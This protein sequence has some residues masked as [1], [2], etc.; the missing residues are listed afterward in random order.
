MPYTTVV[1]GTAITASWGNANVRD[2][3]VTP[4]ASTSA[5][6][7]AITSPVTG[8]VAV[9]T[10]TMAVW[11]RKSGAWRTL[12]SAPDRYRCQLRQTSGTSIPSGS[13]TA[14]TWDTEDSDV[15]NWHSTS[16]NTSR[17]T[18]NIAG[19]LIVA[20]SV[21]TGTT[22]SWATTELRLN[23]GATVAYGGNQNPGPVGGAWH[24]TGFA[25]V[26]VN[27]TSDYVEVFM[28][29]G[30]AGSLTTDVNRTFCTAWM[31]SWS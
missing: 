30:T 9:T 24:L 19:T 21:S 22:T 23:G 4:F 11:I 8:M 16:S 7:S 3:C 2:Q 5:R 27:G 25:R 10:D 20:W 17:I 14:V 18:P 6:D 31:E 13:F 28:G 29:Q 12:R 15:E 1:A 26:T